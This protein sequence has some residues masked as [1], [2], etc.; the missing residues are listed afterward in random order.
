MHSEYVDAGTHYGCR[1]LDVE[2]KRHHDEDGR[3]REVPAREEHDEEAE[4]EAAEGDGGVVEAEARPPVGLLEDVLEQA[5]E[6]DEGVAE[7]EEHCDDGCH[8]VDVTRG[9]APGADEHL[10]R[11]RG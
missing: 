9:D 7:Q 1:Y 2:V 8:A 3:E 11:V 5:C 4:H 10:V 6:V